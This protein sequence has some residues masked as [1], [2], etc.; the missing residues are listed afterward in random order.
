MT[1]FLASVSSPEEASLALAAGVDIIDLKDPSSGALGALPLATVAA[2]VERIAGRRPCSATIGDL[3]NQVDRVTEAVTNV[4]ATGVDIVKVG[5][6]DPA[7]A[8]AVLGSLEPLAKNDTR[9]VV[10]LFADRQ[11]DVSL[12]PIIAAVGCLGVML[13]TAAKGSGSL[14]KFMDHQT[15]DRF[16]RQSRAFGLLTGLAG[17]LASQDIAPLLKLDPDFLGFRG[18]LC[19]GAAR[20]QDLD[21]QKLAQV[22]R[23][24]PRMEAAE[25]PITPAK[26]AS[27]KSA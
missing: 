21:V 11:A 23:L 8:H 5:I 17:S 1:R 6:F 20:T 10:V 27:L 13:D 12:L 7:G 9:I 15:L 16:V 18:A 4:A 3:P 25:R 24:I 26:T 14:R 2:A 19:R 22:R